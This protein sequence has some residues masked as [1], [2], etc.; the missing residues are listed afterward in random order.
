M[1]LV[2]AREMCETVVVCY[3]GSRNIRVEVL[4]PQTQQQILEAVDQLFGAITEALQSGPKTY[5]E[6]FQF[7]QT[8]IMEYGNRTLS[9]LLLGLVKKVAP[10]EGG[11]EDLKP[12][13]LAAYVSAIDTRE[14]AEQVLR[15]M[16]EPDPRKLATNLNTLRLTLPT[17]RQVLLPISKR[18]PPP[19]GG[20][21]KLEIDPARRQA[22]K[23]RIGF[24]LANDMELREAAEQVAQEQDL[25]VTRVLI[26]WRSG[27]R[28]KKQK[29]T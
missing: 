11:D 21:P 20:R 26:T 12:E 10:I 15:A 25:T 17:I 1:K 6:V 13:L 8:K 28:K 4:E 9:S 27:R 22:I 5:E 29:P 2:K 7:V 3:S 16:P 23:E 18:L 19:P 24:L 14:K